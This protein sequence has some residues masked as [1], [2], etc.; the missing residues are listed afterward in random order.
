MSNIPSEFYRAD[1]CKPEAMTIGEL[2]EVLQK[3]P[4]DLEFDGLQKVTVY[5]IGRPSQC[6][7]IEDS[8]QYD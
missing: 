5:N 3:L 1:I 8:D 7:K 2:I 4:P 6:V